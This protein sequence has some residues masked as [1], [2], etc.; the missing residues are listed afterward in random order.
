MFSILFSSYISYNFKT[1]LTTI[2]M[3]MNDELLLSLALL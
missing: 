2:D 1:F 3:K